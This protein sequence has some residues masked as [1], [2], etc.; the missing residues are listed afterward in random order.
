MA[1]QSF[2]PGKGSNRDPKHNKNSSQS[3]KNIDIDYVD[4]GSQKIPVKVEPKRK[5][6]PALD[7]FSRD[8]TKLAAEGR[9]DPMIGREE[10]LERMI[11][12]L[13]RKGKCNPVLLGDAGVGKTAIVEGLAQKI[14]SGEIPF[15]EG[16]RVC[17][18]D[19]T[20]MLAGTMYRGQFEERLKTVIQEV[21]EAKDVILFIDELHT[22]IGAGAAKG[23]M[24]L[25]NMLKP[26]LA[27]GEVQ[28]IGATTYNEY[29]KY[30]ESDAAMA[31]RFQPVDVPEPSVDDTIKI[32]RGLKSKLERHHGIKISDEIITSAVHG[33]QRYIPARFMPDKAIDVLDEAAAR[34]QVAKE[35]TLTSKRVSEVLANISGVPVQSI[36]AEEA[37]RYIELESNLNSEVIGQSEAV[38]TISKALMRARAGLRDPNRPIG[39]FLALGPTGVGK[40]HLC[41]RLAHHLFGD[42]NALIQF[43]MSEYMEKH[44]VSRLIG[45]PP[46]YVGH[47][48]GGQLTEA[49]RRKPYAV[50]LL[51]EIDKAHPEALNILLQAF[52]EGQLTD[53]QGRRVSCKNVLFIMT[54]NLGVEEA[55]RQPFGLA[56]GISR[57]DGGHEYTKQ[58]MLDKLHQ[59]WRPELINRL[60]E[61]L[62]FRSLDEIQCAAILKRE[63]EIFS[64]NAARVGY[65]VEVTPDVA[66]FLLKKGFDREY[67]ARPLR[68]AV[69]HYLLDTLSDA[70]LSGSVPKNTPLL[71]VLTGGSISFVPYENIPRPALEPVAA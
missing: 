39:A 23:G 70:I 61:V 38:S 69:E 57:T 3:K 31:R 65:Q 15:L 8:L 19:V 58:R 48:Q 56:A 68:R 36:N 26:L 32:C 28:C 64:Q 53:G 12:V 25:S 17:A 51:D 44:N 50:V 27:R 47:D 40:T 7:G 55:N 54:S 35:R 33:A 41:K 4:S 63:L 9:L 43:D 60:D 14:A 10:Q 22:V 45:S 6:T 66:A 62:V 71:A 1:S 2:G 37:S 52:E 34:A 21:L 29:R 49:I 46:G 42:A 67:G 5:P 20:A 18:L 59:S 16:K 11:Q 30:F 13:L 24:D